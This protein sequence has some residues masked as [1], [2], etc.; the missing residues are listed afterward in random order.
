MRL[1]LI[2]IMFSIST[3]LAFA[4]EDSL[5]GWCG[6][7]LTTLSVMVKTVIREY[8]SSRCEKNTNLELGKACL[9][10]RQ[11]EMD[12]VID[13]WNKVAGSR[14]QIFFK[15]PKPFDRCANSCRFNW[16]N[17]FGISAKNCFRYCI[18]LLPERDWN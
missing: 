9:K 10:G 7:K 6:N 2:C 13:I 16:D 12:D 1:I 5:K 3:T 15:R 14:C 11:E 17:D 18:P 4:G 8:P